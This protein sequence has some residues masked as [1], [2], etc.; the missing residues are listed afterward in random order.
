MM[1]EWDELVAA[2]EAYDEAKAKEEQALNRLYAAIKDADKC[3]WK[4]ADITHVTGYSRCWVWRIA[5]WEG[6][7]P[8]QI[9]GRS[10][11]VA[12]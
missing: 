4:A 12:S 6:P 1:Q 10:A 7:A 9:R 5:K 11:K 2:T 8:V 3:G